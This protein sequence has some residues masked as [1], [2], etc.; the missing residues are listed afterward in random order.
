ME[1][2]DLQSF[3]IKQFRM[4]RLVK[5]IWVKY[6]PPSI[7]W[8]RSHSFLLV[9]NLGLS[10]FLLVVFFS[11]FICTLTLFLFHI[12]LFAL[13]HKQSGLV[14]HLQTRWFLQHVH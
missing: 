1:K 7:R 8:T 3:S 13:S 2:I 11:L 14:I 10:V 6:F 4:V 12:L 5:G 9:D